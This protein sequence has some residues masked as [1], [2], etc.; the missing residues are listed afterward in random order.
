[1]A[2]LFIARAHQEYC[3]R[4]FLLF[5]FFKFKMLP[6]KILMYNVP[7]LKKIFAAQIEEQGR[8]WTG[9]LLSTLLKCLLSLKLVLLLTSWNTIHLN[10]S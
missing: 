9:P 3:F 2:N 5:F 10:V 7:V 4:P 6:C 1:M 8:S